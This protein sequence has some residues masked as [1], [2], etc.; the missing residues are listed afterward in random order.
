MPLDIIENQHWTESKQVR[1]P[2]SKKKRIQKKWRKQLKNFAIVPRSDIA[3]ID[4]PSIF[5]KVTRKTIVCHPVTAI[6]IK[7]A[8]KEY[9]TSYSL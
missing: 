6:K 5:N 8:L 9:E 2:R 3:I 7:S 1:Y 4:L